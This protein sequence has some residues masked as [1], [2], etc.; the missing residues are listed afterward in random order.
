MICLS[1]LLSLSLARARTH[2]HTH[3]LF[4]SQTYTPMRNTH[5]QSDILKKQHLKQHVRLCT[6]TMSSR[7]LSFTFSL[8][9]ARTHKLSHFLS[10]IHTP[11][12]NTHTQDNILKKQHL[13][14]QLRLCTHTT[15]SLFL[16][17][18]LSLFLSRARARTLS[19]SFSLKHTHLCA[20]HTR[21]VTFSKSS[22]SSSC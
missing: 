12:R 4:L 10:Q 20:T 19:L 14:Q 8:V 11:M 6:H 15:G 22:I 2:T 1:L 21:G 16:S 5:K 13:M 3:S 18:S 7:F 17:L 9:R